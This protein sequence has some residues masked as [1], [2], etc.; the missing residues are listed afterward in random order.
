M[1]GY[2]QRPDATEKTFD[3][4]GWLRTGDIAEII[5]GKIFIRGRIKDILVTSTGEKI[6]RADLEV[7]I[8]HD[9]LFEQIVVVGEGKPYL[10][11]LIVLN[12]E[13]WARFATELGLDCNDPASLRASRVND[14]VLQRI[15]AQLHEFPAYAQIRAVYLTLEPWTIDNGLMTS[16]QKLRRT[17]IMDYLEDAINTLY[18]GH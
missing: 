9:T 1:L 15:N 4:E 7:A 10:A 16:T 6:P 3:S 8:G 18:A 2:W 17:Q 11:A 14:A 13:A 5:D 12:N